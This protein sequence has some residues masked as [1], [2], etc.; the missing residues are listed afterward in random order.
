[1][2]FYTLLGAVVGV[3]GGSGLYDMDGLSQVKSIELSTPFGTDIRIDGNVGVIHP[4]P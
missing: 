3:I 4:S 1:V 2:T